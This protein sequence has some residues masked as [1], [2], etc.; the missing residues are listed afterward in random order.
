MKGDIKRENMEEDL[1]NG[2]S[3]DCLFK[4]TYNNACMSFYEEIYVVEAI[5]RYFLNLLMNKNMQQRQ[6][7]TAGCVMLLWQVFLRRKK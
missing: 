7:T 2:R 4:F 5:F 6:N 1:N 3:V